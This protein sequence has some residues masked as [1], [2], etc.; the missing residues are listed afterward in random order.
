MLDL[1]EFQKLKLLSCRNNELKHLNISNGSSEEEL[2]FNGNAQIKSICA[3]SMEY[4][5][6]DSMLKEYHY[7]DCK[8]VPD[9]L[10]NFGH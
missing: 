10:D 2:N 5:I 7:N 4:D 1:S 8:I 6:L 3:D 9:C